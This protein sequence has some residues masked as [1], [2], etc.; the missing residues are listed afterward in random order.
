MSTYRQV[1]LGEVHTPLIWRLTE[2]SI[3]GTIIT[4]G[5]SMETVLNRT[6]TVRE[7]MTST[8][9]VKR[10]IGMGRFWGRSYLKQCP[11]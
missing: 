2:F 5:R 10:D 8:G 4:P 1:T 7:G 3:G 9:L 11:A 6:P